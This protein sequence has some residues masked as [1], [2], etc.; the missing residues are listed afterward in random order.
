MKLMECNVKKD[1]IKIEDL[2][3]TVAMMAKA[4]ETQNAVILCL[5][6]KFNIETDL[7]TWQN[8]EIFEKELGAKVDA[9]VKAIRKIYGHSET[10]KS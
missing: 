3:D 5:L 2:A 4:I 6:H 1:E 7:P 8:K 9:C 10:N